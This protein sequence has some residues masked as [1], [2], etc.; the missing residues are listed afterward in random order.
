MRIT[1]L[2]LSFTLFL[3]ISACNKPKGHNKRKISIPILSTD[4]NTIDSLNTS[5]ANSISKFDK[6]KANYLLFLYAY[7]PLNDRMDYQFSYFSNFVDITI[8]IKHN[9]PWGE[10]VPENIFKHFVLPHRINNE[11]L[12]TSR[13]FF[14]HQL[15][16]RIDTMD[17]LDAAL[18][19]DHWCHEHV[20]YQ[21][22]DSR[23]SAPIATYKKGYG[24]C[25]EESVF[26]VA[27]LRAV[28]IP[29]RQVYTPRWAHTDD[30]HAWVEFW[31]NGKWYFFG[32][33]EPVAEPNTGWFT[34]PARRAML[35]ESRVFGPYNGKENILFAN[36]FRSINN[37][38][39][40]Y[41]PVSK[42][43]IKVVD[44]NN[45][46]VVNAKVDYQ[47]YNYAEFYTLF[48]A[49][50]DK[51]GI[52]G[53]ETGHG[54]LL[55]WAHTDSS[56]S[57]RM[58]RNI[59]TDTFTIVLNKIEDKSYTLNLNYHPPVRPEPKP[60]NQKLVDKN[61]IRLTYEDSL[62]KSF[63]SSYLDSLSSVEIANKNNIDS[64]DF[65]LMI[66]KSRANWNEIVD[67]VN[68]APNNLKT[69]AMNILSNISLKD[70]QDCKAG[71]LLNHLNNTI[72]FDK[73][74]N[75][76]EKTYI[77]YVLNPRIALEDLWPWR[78][79]LKNCL[80]KDAKA[81]TY[82]DW[83]KKN[84]QINDTMNYSGVQINPCSVY[85]L[86]LADRMSRDLLLIAMWRANGIASRFE[87]GTSL[88][89]YYKD[90]EWHSLNFDES[91]DKKTTYGYLHLET[92]NRNDK[93]LYYKHFTIAKLNKGVYKTLS[94]D[95]D[96]N[97]NTFDKKIKL[98]TGNYRLCTGNR[99]P[100]GS[101]LAIFKFF[102]IEENKVKNL[103]VDIRKSTYETKNLGKL[104]EINK[105]AKT[106]SKNACTISNKSF[107]I[108]L[109]YHPNN[110]PSKHALEDIAKVKKSLN[111]YNTELWL[112]GEKEYAKKVLDPKYFSSLL[113]QTYY[114]TD[115]GL[116]FLKTA[117]TKI[118]RK[119]GGEYPY[120]ILLN[121]KDEIIFVTEGYTIGLGEEINKL[122][123]ERLN[124]AQLSK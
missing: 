97:I 20:A 66:K 93:L 111:A 61:K 92:T 94:F 109:W 9:M 75:I 118:N 30:N 37:S 120:I 108:L 27:A 11:N 5:I 124:R 32:A 122:I 98:S 74:E 14:Y 78:A 113:P 85:H 102:N 52:A 73:T 40:V 99:M 49:T 8:K 26:T 115:K 77:K 103:K 67:F 114:F 68:K 58:L 64:K 79:C 117:E 62:R 88:P 12:D 89:Q 95:W 44:T 60:I 42:L 17:M 36:S 83:I 10:K 50:T 48:R 13:Q 18:E 82:F 104:S 116:E 24:R 70:L 34:E 54:D 23:T 100:D 47:I 46:A 56:Y 1:T 55:I 38:L 25:G 15:K 84:I 107:K 86:H 69:R 28:G 19:V 71:I 4:N 29:A 63:E 3:A 45:N 16:S 90:G 31:A 59:N 87:E 2:F 106:Q 101:V 123:K 57:Y 41:A 21:A 72:A 65:W 6:E 53:F 39:Y 81:I 43:Y 22:S 33:C 96:K 80:G 121:P 119:F 91:T 105:F 51:N 7:M 110:E 76:P 35:V 112:I